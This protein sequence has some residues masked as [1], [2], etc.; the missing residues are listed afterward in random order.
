M[1]CCQLL[2]VLR[3]VYTEQIEQVVRTAVSS[4]L[5]GDQKV[6]VRK[7]CQHPGASSFTSGSTQLWQRNLQ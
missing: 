4:F 7:V 6:A 2:I 5:A 1:D 3:L